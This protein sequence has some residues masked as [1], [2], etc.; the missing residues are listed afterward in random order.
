MFKYPRN[1]LFHEML[2]ET[3]ISRLFYFTLDVRTAWEIRR[4]TPMTGGIGILSS[5]TIGRYRLSKQEI[6]DVPKHDTSFVVRLFP[7]ASGTLLMQ[8]W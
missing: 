3:F 2:K 5:M 1:I 7:A 4:F 6:T 8:N